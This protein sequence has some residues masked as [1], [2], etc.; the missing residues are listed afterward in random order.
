MKNC[1]KNFVSIV[2]PTARGRLFVYAD[3]ETDRVLI[4][5]GH[6]ALEVPFM[7][8]KSEICPLYGAFPQ[9]YGNYA[10]TKNDVQETF[11]SPLSMKKLISTDRHHA[12][13]TP[14]M[15]NIGNSTA[16]IFKSDDG[17][18][19]AVNSYFDDAARD[20][21][22]TLYGSAGSCYSSVASDTKKFSSSPILISVDDT[23]TLLMLPIKCDISG[24]I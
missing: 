1:F 4:T 18:Y 10:I 21:F 24:T 11:G 14:Y 22:S 8:Y 7:T 13:W 15:I 6:I 9:T 5:E 2:K 12:R 16:R 20:I 17:H 19:A 3:K 23:I